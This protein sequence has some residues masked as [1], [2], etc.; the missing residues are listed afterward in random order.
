MIIIL[1]VLIVVLFSL[2]ITN[3]RANKLVTERVKAEQINM[4]FQLSRTVALLPDVIEG[5]KNESLAGNIQILTNQITQQTGVRF[6]VVMNMNGTRKSHPNPNEIGKKFV[7]GDEHSVLAGKE[8]SSISEGTLGM[9]LRA[10]T[11]IFAEN[12]E[13]LGAVAVGV[14]FDKI[15]REVMA[16]RK[17]NIISTSYGLLIGI[18]GALL[19]ARYIK[20]TLFGLEPFEI[21]KI[22]EERDAMLDSVKEGIL[23]VDKD[24]TITILNKSG[25]EILE[26][27]GIHDLKIGEKVAPF[28]EQLVLT[29][30]QIADKTQFDEEVIIN[31][32]ELITNRVPIC[33]DNEVVGSISTFRDK[34][35]MKLLVQQLT[36]IKLYAE[37][38][39][40][41]SHEFMNHL[42]VILGLTSL[43]EYDELQ[44]YI[45]EIAYHSKS[46]HT[47]IT[48]KIKNP[49]LAGFF[50][51]KLS[52]AREK[53]VL[54]R[55]KIE[56]VVPNIHNS[57]ITHELIMILGNLIDNALEAVQDSEQKEVNV[58]VFYEEE[59][60][61]TIVE[62]LGKGIK[63]Q[64]KQFLF[65]KDFS[66]KGRKRGYGLYLVKQSI[67][68]HNGSIAFTSEVNKGTTFVVEIQYKVE[69]KLND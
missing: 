34:T 35:E 10:F 50:V 65:D 31:G 24:T 19:I 52:N 58:S 13:Q 55:I 3:V 51:G 47:N 44:T 64:E 37:A 42:H 48:S 59:L 67:E 5:L 46:E 2:F 28:L 11:P 57:N 40:S 32:V 7:G 27:S 60:L 33:I 1:L 36:G 29:D 26:R 25:A 62:D 14:H 63:E 15:N 43:K 56:Q 12:G 54:L 9:S 4:A 41:Q 39:R 30:D 53:N 22:L 38:L 45:D 6:I 23:A 21:A 20:K 8:S 69:G 18:V 66:T 49:Y 61:T 68:K 16:E 17:E